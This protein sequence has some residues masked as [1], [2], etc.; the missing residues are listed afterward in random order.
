MDELSKLLQIK[1]Y[2]LEIKLQLAKLHTQKEEAI[3]SQ[4]YERAADIRQQEKDLHS[5]L[6]STRLILQERKVPPLPTC[7]QLKEHEL[8]LSIL[9]EISTIDESKVDYR[10]IRNE[11]FDMLQAETKRLSQDKKELLKEK[12]FWAVNELHRQMIEIG[13][14]LSKVGR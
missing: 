11:F 13:E 12:E 2:V 5:V 14:F 10:N 6:L 1:V 9:S 3:Q 7:D 8:G 4:Y